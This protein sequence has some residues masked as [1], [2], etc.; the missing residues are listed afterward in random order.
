M[1]TP[2][3]TELR[4]SKRI[5]IACAV[6]HNIAI[7]WKTPL[8]EGDDVHNAGDDGNDEVI[9]SGCGTLSEK[10]C[11]GNLVLILSFCTP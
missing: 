1:K 7:D 5:I 2:L 4:T 9:N 8:E 11:G 6:L 10:C 3:R